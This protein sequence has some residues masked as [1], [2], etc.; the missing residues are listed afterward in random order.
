MDLSGSPVI[1]K[2]T[3]AIFHWAQTAAI[4]NFAIPPLRLP[5]LLSAISGTA[6]QQNKKCLNNNCLDNTP[7]LR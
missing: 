6:I 2:Q 3:S 4:E 7:S 5:V 1:G